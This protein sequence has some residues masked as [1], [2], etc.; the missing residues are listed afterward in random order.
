MAL[1]GQ[2]TDGQIL[3]QS[4]SYRQGLVLGLTMAEI[5]IL[6]VFCLLIALATFLSL[7]QKGR[8]KAEAALRVEQ[9]DSAVGRDLVEAIKQNP[10]LFEH[11]KSLASSAEASDEFWRELVE[12]RSIVTEA[13]DS[14][15]SE[16]ELRQRLAE[17][18]T[19]KARGIDPEQAL[20][21]ADIVASI[22]K[23]MPAVSEATTTPEEV[24]SA[25]ER[26]L[27]GRGSS[28]HQWPPIISLSEANGYYFKSGSAEL[29]PD[30]R[31][32]LISS[33]P[34]RILAIIKQFDVDVIEVLG[35]TDEQPLVLRQSNLD[36]DLVPVLR[37]NGNIA[38]L[39]PADNAG[40]G[41]A[42]AASVVS[43][44]LQ[45]PK[46]ADYKLI[47]LSGAQLVNTDESLALSGT[48]GDIPERRRIEIRLRKSAPHEASSAKAPSIPLP[49]SKPRQRPNANPVLPTPPANPGPP[50]NIIRD[51]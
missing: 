20:R 36:R 2:A 41:L 13:K 8:E 29:T 12:A 43:V 40:L 1:A 17:L 3:R 21:N 48:P 24:A 45:S 31:A 16:M 39:V 9:A 32:S 42:R 5:M 25:V 28:G 47:P 11:V 18:G 4:S 10:E 23:V 22:R 30:F 51:R 26:G 15:I 46:L 34:D 44:L 7:E 35:H 19:L 49:L 37:D 33:I 14:G 6:L 27:N 50:S 38:S